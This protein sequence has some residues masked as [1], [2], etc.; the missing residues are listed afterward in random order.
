MPTNVVPSE[1]EG[2]TP[3]PPANAVPPA[4][5]SGMG[6]L[7]ALLVGAVILLAG[8]GVGFFIWNKSS[9]V[10]RGSLITSA[11]NELKKNPPGEDK[12]EEKSAPNQPE[13][14]KMEI[15]FPPPMT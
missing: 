9:A 4:E 14:K 12:D 5:G 2:T 13:K 8:G 6:H 10:T 15:K 7:V 3:A 1:S 11:M